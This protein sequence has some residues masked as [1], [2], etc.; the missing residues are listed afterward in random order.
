MTGLD[1]IYLMSF[2]AGALAFLGFVGACR[3]TRDLKIEHDHNFLNAMLSIVG[4][5]VSILLGLLVAS[6][7]DN[8]RNLEKVV[9]GEAATVAQVFR[10]SAG[11]PEAT[12]NELR[13][14]CEQYS[15]GVV[16]DEWPMM[17][18]GNESDNITETT[19]KLIARVVKFRPSTEGESNI[20]AELLQAVQNVSDGRRQ[21]ILALHNEWKQHLAPVLL[22]CSST[23]QSVEDHQ[24]RTEV[25]QQ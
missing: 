5:L 13:T 20:H 10:L 18:R 15:S 4:T 17:E 11:V 8:Y 25:E 3:V 16:S 19:I 9:D 21:R 24:E 6:A 1:P 22:M 23:R 7:L 12:G 14:L 2:A